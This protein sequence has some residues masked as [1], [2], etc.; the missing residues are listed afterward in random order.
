MD[1]N[2]TSAEGTINLMTIEAN[3]NGKKLDLLIQTTGTINTRV[4]ELAKR[5]DRIENALISLT[6]TEEKV[7]RL[8][9][10]IR[11]IRGSTSE[12]LKSNF[13]AIVEAEEVFNKYVKENSNI[14]EYGKALKE[15]S[16][17]S[18][19]EHIQ[20][21]KSVDTLDNVKFVSDLRK[22]NNIHELFSWTS[23]AMKWSNTMLLGMLCFLIMGV[24]G[25]TVVFSKPAEPSPQITSEQLTRII[26]QVIE[27]R[28][29]GHTVN[30]SVK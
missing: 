6:R 24:I 19:I 29:H 22:N 27:K 11:T 28:L 3:D 30:D 14:I 10:D 15:K 18:A 16:A 2:T 17:I 8:E 1:T 5:T 25:A 13:E 20:E 23:T 26:D 21:L 9:E 7:V 12:A 4:E